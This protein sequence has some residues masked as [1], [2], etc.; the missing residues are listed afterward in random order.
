MRNLKNIYIPKRYNYIATFLTLN[1]NMK[2]A[3]CINAHGGNRTF[4]NSIILGRGW[5]EGLNRLVCSQDLPITLQGGEPSLHPDFVWIINNIRPEL[6]IDILTN[7]CF[8]VERF[9]GEVSPFRL[10]RDAFY[11]IIRVSYHPDHISLDDLIKKVLKMQK[12][13]FSIGIYGILHPEFSKKALESQRKCR[14]LGIDFKLKEF[15]GDYNSKLYGTYRYPEAIG[16]NGRKKCL[17]RTSELII[18]PDC[19]IYRCH[20]DLYKDFPP[21]GNL[22]DPDFIIEDIF[23][24]CDQFGNCNPCDLKVKTNRFQVYGHASVEIENIGVLG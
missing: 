3:Y 18:G 21:I 24:E 2:C 12:A 6:K 4:K 8:D 22:L 19:D 7:L 13:G 10:C 11:P 23:R 16:N 9:I 5:I 15:L 14:D 1:C 20:H 17:C